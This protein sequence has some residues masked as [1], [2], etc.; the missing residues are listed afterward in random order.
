MD[1]GWHDSVSYSMLHSF[2]IIPKLPSAFLA[3]TGHRAHFFTG[4]PVFCDLFPSKNSSNFTF[5]CN[6]KITF[7]SMC[8]TFHQSV[9]NLIA[10]LHLDF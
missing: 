2:L 10:I 7:L 4:L 8:L 1:L 3:T 5:V 6:I 9:P